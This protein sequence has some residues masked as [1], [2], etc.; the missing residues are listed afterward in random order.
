[1][2]RAL[3]RRT[4]FLAM[5][6]LGWHGFKIKRRGNAARLIVGTSPIMQVLVAV[7][8]VGAF[9]WLGMAARDGNL[10]GFAPPWA[11]WTGSMTIALCVLYRYLFHR[12]LITIKGGGLAVE[13][14]P[15][16]FPL[17]FRVSL[18][19][20]NSVDTDVKVTVHRD[21]YGHERESYTFIVQLS[22]QSD[23]RPKRLYRTGSE[24]A[25]VTFRQTLVMMIEN[26]RAMGG[27]RG[28]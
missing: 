2:A 17:S 6:S 23:Y 8:C 24:T 10:P 26:A 5:A 22:L 15:I 25:A 21:K 16:P 18:P 27:G 20:I 1:V 28:F 12:T 14:R 19:D 3:A 4:E 11:I 9:V 7:L 13:R